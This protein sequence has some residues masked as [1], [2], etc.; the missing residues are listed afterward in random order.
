MAMFC[1]QCEQTQSGTGCV[2][3]GKCGKD[4]QVAA[5][6]DVLV[7]IAKEVAVA[8]SAKPA[9]PTEAGDFVIEAMFLTVTNVNFDPPRF[10]EAAKKGVAIRDSLGGSGKAWNLSSVEALEAQAP[11]HSISV[12]TLGVGPDV[13]GLQELTLYGIKGAAAYLHHAN[14]L[15]KHDANVTSDLVKALAALHPAPVDIEQLAGMALSAGEINLRVMAMLDA[16]HVET[17]GHPEPSPVRI[18]P[19]EGKCILVSGHDLLDLKALLEQ[20]EGTGINVYTHGEMLPAHGY[21]E[22]KKH[23]HLA[24]N[25]GGAWQ[26][27]QK[28]FRN[29]PGPILMTTNCIQKPSVDY[30]N[31]IYTCGLVGWPGVKHIEGRDFSAL[32]QAAKAA[33]G[34]TATEP[35]ETIL[36][37]FARNTILQ[38]AGTVLDAIN[39]GALKHIFLIGGCDGA[40]FERNYYTKIAEQVPNDCV[41]LTLGCGKFRFNKM[42]FG[43]LGGLPRLMDVGQCND[44][45]SAIIVAVELAKAVG[46]GVNDLPLS[47]VLSWYEQKAVAILLTLLH[48]GV[49]DIRVGPTVPA[50]LSPAVVGVLNERFGLNAISTP[51]A[52]LAACLN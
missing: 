45:Y 2:S 18:T 51:E 3:Q 42:D 15:G 50:F 7:I 34:F 25:Y 21:P 8:A 22:L 11:D 36:T 35:E 29:F 52:D 16:G 23:K 1:Y 31:T 49:K 10:L 20:T 28:E 40:L 14:V 46:C 43:T 6:Q 44:A 32:I 12:R 13:T 37:G 24:G 47:L 33:P 17:F 9:V 19:V 39:A 48:L 38:H 41:I 27:Q 5:L 4:P 26:D 30:I